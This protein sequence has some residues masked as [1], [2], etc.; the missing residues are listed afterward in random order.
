MDPF[1][2]II[3]LSSGNIQL[4]TFAQVLIVSI[5]FIAPILFSWMHL[6]ANKERMA[7]R[8]EV[9]NDQDFDFIVGELIIYIKQKT[10]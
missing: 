3:T 7:G 5:E 9:I 1:N 10:T 2:Q 6:D 4:T 8:F